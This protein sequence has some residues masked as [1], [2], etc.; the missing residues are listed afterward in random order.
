[1]G[2]LKRS[3][4]PEGRATEYFYDKIAPAPGGGRLVKEA[5]E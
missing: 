3:V 1:M 4:D 2:Q 5:H